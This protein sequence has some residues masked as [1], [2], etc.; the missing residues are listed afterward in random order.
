MKVGDLV[1]VT[2][3]LGC[4]TPPRHYRHRGFGVVVEIKETKPFSWGDV[5]NISLGKDVTVALTTGKVEIF[6]DRSVEVVYE[7]R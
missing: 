5:K 4:H 6:S 3:A 7:S 2:Q 1:S